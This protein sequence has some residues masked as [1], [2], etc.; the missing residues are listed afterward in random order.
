MQFSL[1]VPVHNGEQY[2]KRAVDSALNQTLPFYEII[3]VENGS[4]DNSLAIC[5]FYEQEYQQIKLLRSTPK[6]VSQARNQGLDAATGEYVLFLDADDILDK[7]LIETLTQKIEE[8]NS[9]CDIYQFNFT[10]EFSNGTTKIN[11]YILPEGIYK[12]NEFMYQS[13]KKFREEMKHMVW[14]MAFKKST[15][16]RLQLRFDTELDM[17]ED[18]LFLQTL[19]AYDIMILVL[20]VVLVKY[21][22]TLT[23]LTQQTNPNYIM[24]FTFLSIKMT[25]QQMLIQNQYI[26]YLGGK[27]LTLSEY[28]HFFYQGLS[29]VL[30]VYEYYRF[31]FRQL[32]QKITKK[33]VKR[34]GKR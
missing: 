34:K 9:Q 12:G 10:Q 29:T 27:I 25:Q 4:T 16:D 33:V 6:G 15:L 19:Y 17:F 24:N 14:S 3:L 28:V 13:I 7:L 21:S 23:S 2:I 20:H 31:Q 26:R 11:P 8:N 30:G 5:Q 32:C 1:I 18:I 22:Y